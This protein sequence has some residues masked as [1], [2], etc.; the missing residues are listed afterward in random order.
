MAGIHKGWLCLET[1]NFS[2]RFME[3]HFVP[4][5]L[6]LKFCNSGNKWLKPILIS[7]RNALIFLFQ[8]NFDFI[9]ITLFRF[10]IIKM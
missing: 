5:S 10:V 2:H 4:Y 7:S 8:N 1:A 9:F 6:H 3:H